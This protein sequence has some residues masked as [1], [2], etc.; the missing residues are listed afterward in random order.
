MKNET[1][2]KMDNGMA[3]SGLHK[4]ISRIKWTTQMGHE[5]DATK[6]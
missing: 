6:M 1:E 3:T 4:E 5:T 2:K